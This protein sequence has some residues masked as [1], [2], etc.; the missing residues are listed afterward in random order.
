M[1]IIDAALRVHDWHPTEVLT[2]MGPGTETA[3]AFWARQRG[4]SPRAFW[5][6]WGVL[7]EAAGPE[8][9]ERLIRHGTHL[10]ALWDGKSSNTADLIE[11]ARSKNMRCIVL[12]VL[13]S[14]ATAARLDEERKAKRRRA[15]RSAAPSGPTPPDALPS[16]A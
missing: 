2:P 12:E 14:P 10:L 7:G 15:P 16:A 11:R 4:I 1:L 3:G 13:P 6:Q 9:N 5:P 8:C